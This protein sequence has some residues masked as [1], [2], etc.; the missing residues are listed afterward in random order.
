MP[1]AARHGAGRWTGRGAHLLGLH[2]GQEVAEEQMRNLF[3]HRLHLIKEETGRAPT[4]AGESKIKT[5][6]AHRQ[7]AAVA[8]TR[9]SRCP[10]RSRAATA[11]GAGARNSRQNSAPARSKD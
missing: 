4:A 2:D 10:A 6:E 5:Q 7:R 11:S 1:P 8:C 9:T 3:G